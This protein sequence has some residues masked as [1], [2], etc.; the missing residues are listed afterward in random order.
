MSGETFDTKDT[1]DT[2]S[3]PYRFFPSCPWCPLCRRGVRTEPIGQ[4][5]DRDRVRVRA[6]VVENR[7]VAGKHEI[8]LLGARHERGIGEVLRQRLAVQEAHAELLPA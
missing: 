4:H 3:K 7:V 1:K 8:V 2:K 6:V 5:T